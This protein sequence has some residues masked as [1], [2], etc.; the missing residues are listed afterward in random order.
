MEVLIIIALIVAGLL[1]FI[2]EV[3]LI[4]GISI[5]GIASAICL[6]YGNYYAFDSLG[7]TAGF[8]TLA[9]TALGCIGITIWF[10][11]SKT[12]DKLS[13]KKTLDYKIDPLKGLNINVGDKGVA[14]TRLALIGNAEINGHIIE[15]RSADGL[16]NEK[17]PVYVERIVESTV[18]VRELK[19]N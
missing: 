16:I 15:V 3:F 19:K 11:H 10:M 17:T 1:L 14:I 9:A 13:L 4:P 5:A 7:I 18:I 6:L 8:I 2:V 12:V